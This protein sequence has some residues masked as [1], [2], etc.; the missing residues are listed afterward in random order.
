MA[1]KEIEILT[2]NKKMVN[3]LFFQCYI[4]SPLII[5]VLRIV[6][7]WENAYLKFSEIVMLHNEQILYFQ[8]CKI[9]FSVK[10]RNKVH[11][12]I[13]IISE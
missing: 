3:K 6:S 7:G 4:M 10:K 12:L 2:V 1:N 8:L 5:M 9:N 13:V 11:V